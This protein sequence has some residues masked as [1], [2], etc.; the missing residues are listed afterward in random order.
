M[1]TVRAREYK[2]PELEIRSVY[3]PQQNSEI[4]T[5]PSNTMTYANV[6]RQTPHITTVQ[7][8]SGIEIMIK[9][10]TESMNMFMST[11]Q[12]MMQDFMRSQNQLIQALI[13]KK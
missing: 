6:L 9:Q 11:M 8:A 10:L 4:G 13:S 12:S 2:A 3:N 5:A 1:K 7:P